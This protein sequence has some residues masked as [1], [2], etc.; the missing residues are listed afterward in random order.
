MELQP[1]S[2]SSNPPPEPPSSPLAAI[3]ALLTN[4]TEKARLY[5]Y[6]YWRALPMRQ[7]VHHSDADDLVNDAI[8]RTLD[9]RRE[10]HAA[11]RTMLQHLLRVISSIADE[12]YKEMKKY[13]ELLDVHS[14]LDAA[15]MQMLPQIGFQRMK[16]RLK[17]DVLAVAVLESLLN[18]EKPS[19]AVVTLNISK[20]VYEAARRRVLRRG[21][22]VFSSPRSARA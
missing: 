16:C 20:R 7:T 2:S 1:T 18:D 11:E 8:E 3:E 22:E 15:Q 10:W 12:W 5:R 6:A 17:G 4:A 21:Q 9:G 13:S 14:S 19:E